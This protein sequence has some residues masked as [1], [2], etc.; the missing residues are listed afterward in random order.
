MVDLL[1]ARNDLEHRL[2]AELGLRIARWTEIAAGRNNRLF[3]LDTVGGPSLLGKF[4]G[5]D[6]W[7]GLAREYALLSFLGA[8]GFPGVPR[9][10][11]RSDAP[12]YAVYSFEP[13][14]P[15]RPQ[16]YTT[17]DLRNVAAFAA[18]LHTIASE[19][20]E[21]AI[22]PSIEVCFSLADQLACIDRRLG[23]FA[24]FAASPAAPAAIRALNLRDEITRLIAR[25]TSDLEPGDL[26]RAIPRP[27][28]RLNTA[29]FGPHNILI[30]ADG[31]ITV[32]DCEWGGWDD[33]ARMVMGFVAHNGSEGLSD[34]G[35][36]AFLGGYAAERALSAAEI[37]R[38]ERVG[39]LYDIEWVAVCASGLTPES[40][41]IAEFAVDNFDVQA[42]RAEVIARIEA[43][44]A[45]ARAGTGYRF[46]AN[47]S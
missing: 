41:A 36:A 8:R 10:M 38:F 15:K 37:A 26:G 2:H 5:R 14:T 18:A 32:V 20:D 25:A 7:G 4:Y 35:I 22:R 24:A 45:R 34:D 39:V 29:D 11:L 42:H 40:V 30:A 21:S 43:R 1:A 44:L 13:G 12:A 19:A 46:P 9:A 16:D 23:G 6:P 31:G 27:A 17:A 33:P 28:W 47:P 3:R